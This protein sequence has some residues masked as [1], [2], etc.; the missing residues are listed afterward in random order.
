[1]YL[2]T[3]LFND[4]CEKGATCNFNTKPNKKLHGPLKTIYQ[5]CTNYKDVVTQVFSLVYPN[6]LAECTYATL[7]ILKVGHD[8]AVAHNIHDDIK[9]YDHYS[10]IFADG[11][12]TEAASDPDDAEQVKDHI[13][14]GTKQPACSF[15][16]LGH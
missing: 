6:F 9:H 13:L 14:V 12:L 5:E 3:H 7:Q 4:I 10:V 1:M 16:K 8:F 2:P 15:D 11:S